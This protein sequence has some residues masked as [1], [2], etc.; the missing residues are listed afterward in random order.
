MNKIAEWTNNKTEKT[1][2]YYSGE[3]DIATENREI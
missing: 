3:L 2:I 1:E